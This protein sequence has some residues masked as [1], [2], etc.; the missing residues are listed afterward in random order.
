MGIP[1]QDVAQY[2]GKVRRKLD[3]EAAKTRRVQPSADMFEEV[4][5]KF[6]AAALGG[7]I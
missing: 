2:A 6:I 3:S 1:I 4:N 7:G 5:A